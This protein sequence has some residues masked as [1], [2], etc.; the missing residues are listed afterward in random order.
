MLLT[1][2]TLLLQIVLSGGLTVNGGVGFAG[3]GP[4]TL[5]ATDCATVTQAAWDE[6]SW[7]VAPFDVTAANTTLGAVCLIDFKAYP[8]ASLP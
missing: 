5:S 4:I 3:D 7:Q 6:F 1:V 8:A 2:P